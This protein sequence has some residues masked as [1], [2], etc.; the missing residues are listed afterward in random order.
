MGIPTVPGMGEKREV[1]LP[2]GVFS[3]FPSF[4]LLL[5]RLVVLGLLG[6]L[7]FPVPFCSPGLPV[8]PWSL[9]PVHLALPFL[10]VLPWLGL[11]WH[12]ARCLACPHGGS[13]CKAV[14]LAVRGSPPH[15]SCV[16]AC[17]RPLQ[18]RQDVA[19]EPVCEQEVQLPVQGDH[20]RRLSDQGGRRGRASRHYAGA[21]HCGGSN[22]ASTVAGWLAV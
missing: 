6:R 20:R 7:I 15:E 4:S 14:A 21:S 11:G 12:S 8:L 22:A 1:E 10:V 17:A 3:G 19:D 18:S 16:D 5:R 2:L 9:C 13:P